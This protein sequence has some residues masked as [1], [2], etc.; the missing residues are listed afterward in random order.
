MAPARGGCASAPPG[1]IAP[2]YPARRRHGA[3]SQEMLLS[4]AGAAGWPDRSW[5]RPE[6]PPAI[7]PTP[8]SGDRS[9]RL[10]R[11]GP[12]PARV[13]ASSLGILPVGQTPCCARA[14]PG[15]SAGAWDTPRARGQHEAEGV[16]VREQTGLPTRPSDSCPRA[17]SP[18]PLLVFPQSPSHPRPHSFPSCSSMSFSRFSL[19]FHLL[20]VISPPFLHP[21]F[22]ARPPPCSLLRSVYY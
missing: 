17:L 18:P 7:N 20:C 6:A 15:H 2:I 8:C 1:P 21:L 3:R 14:S 12:R 5:P 11:R 10:G 9:M 22:S 13:P 16:A 19:V 4:P